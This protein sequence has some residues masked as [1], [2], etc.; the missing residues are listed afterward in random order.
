MEIGGVMALK[1]LF[2]ER[3][4]NIEYKGESEIRNTVLT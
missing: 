1:Y 2:E 4:N 3:S